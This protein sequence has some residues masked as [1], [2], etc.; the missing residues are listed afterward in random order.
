MEWLH[1]EIV[2]VT[3]YLTEE[4]DKDLTNSFPLTHDNVRFSSTL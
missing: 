4:E 2:A 1:P 3:V